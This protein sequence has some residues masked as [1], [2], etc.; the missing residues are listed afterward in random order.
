MNP[1]RKP[2]N[3]R[4]STLGLFGHSRSAR[5]APMV[6]AY[7]LSTRSCRS[8]DLTRSGVTITTE[9]H[10]ILFRAHLQPLIQPPRCRNATKRVRSTSATSG[11]RRIVV[12]SVGFAHSS[13]NRCGSGETLSEDDEEALNNDANGSSST[14][15]EDDEDPATNDLLTP[16]SL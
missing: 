4:V 13:H 16:R 8:P 12:L 14:T 11:T 6:L 15:D 10:L 7:S 3:D 1:T 2:R 5:S 9:E